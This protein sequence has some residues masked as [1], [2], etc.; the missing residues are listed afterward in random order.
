LAKI[1]PQ[2]RNAP[3]ARVL[4]SGDGWMASDIHCTAGPHSRPFEEQHAA[5]A[6]ALVIGG[7]FQYRS[8]A[9]EELMTPGSIF[10]GNS[11]Q[12]FECRH[13]HGVGDHCLSFSYTPEFFGR[14][15]SDA[16]S[17]G[18]RHS[19]RALRLPPVRALSG[20]ASEACTA[21][22]GSSPK[23]SWE[24]IA[25]KLAA[26][27]V[28]LDRGASPRGTSGQ[29]GALRRVSEAIRM[30]EAHP[31]APHRLEDLARDA[32]LS[33]YHFLRTFESL[34]GV[35]PHQYVL[36][37]RLRRAAVGLATEAGKVLD[38]ALDSGFGDVSNFNR[39]FHAEFGINPRAYRMGPAN[40]SGKR[41]LTRFREYTN[42]GFSE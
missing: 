25:I 23:H 20:L 19:F 29:P 41:P 28:Q 3:I 8:G 36:R 5:I 12:S 15:A 11:G 37:T 17:G 31:E 39:T 9:G 16:A 18:A 34:V 2:S 33:P 21:F 10:L 24:E 35:T 4:A 40:S 22:A 7:T 6:V 30:V 26:K 38:I 27:S 42:D 14:L 32:R 13:D 1:A